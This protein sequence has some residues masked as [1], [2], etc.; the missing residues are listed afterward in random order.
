MCFKH[1][2][3][4]ISN[5]CFEWTRMEIEKISY[6][7][8]VIIHDTSRGRLLVMQSYDGDGEIAGLG[9]WYIAAATDIGTGIEPPYLPVDGGRCG[10]KSQD[11]AWTEKWHIPLGGAFGL[12]PH[13]PEPHPG[14]SQNERVRPPRG[15][16]TL[17]ACPQQCL[18]WQ[19]KFCLSGL[20][21]QG[22]APWSSTARPVPLVPV[23][24]RGG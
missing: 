17:L 14:A 6:K 3:D 11:E 21:E 2:T 7:A 8:V 1:M 19:P 16:D 12:L 20:A 4:L 5:L 10:E 23:A 15:K 22:S 18:E 24:C 9:R 13:Q